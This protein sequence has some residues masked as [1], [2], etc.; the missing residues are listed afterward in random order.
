MLSSLGVENNTDLWQ[1]DVHIVFSY[2]QYYK[3][4]NF[5]TL[6]GTPLYVPARFPS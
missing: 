1:Q 4:A 2:V 5:V 6:N 3:I